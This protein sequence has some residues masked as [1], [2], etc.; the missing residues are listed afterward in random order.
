[1]R[2]PKIALAI[3]VFALGVALAASSYHVTVNNPVWVGA[4]E[5]K[6]G[7]YQVQ[8]DNGKAVFK[9]KKDTVEVPAKME[10]ADS[11]YQFTSLNTE[12]AGG[13]EKLAGIEIGGTKTRIVIEAPKGS[14]AGE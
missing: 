9:N 7:D 14:A 1:M 3:S 11:K 12:T 8:V 6:A 2:S 4:K 10:N 13:K 5:L